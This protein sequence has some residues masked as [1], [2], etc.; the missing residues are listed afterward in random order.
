[1]PM[2]TLHAPSTVLRW[3]AIFI[4]L[5]VGLGECVALMKA[6]LRQQAAVGRH[7]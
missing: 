7:G 4:A 1:M 3:S 2:R 5:L 6:R